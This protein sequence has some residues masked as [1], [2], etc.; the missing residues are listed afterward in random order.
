MTLSCRDI[1]VRDVNLLAVRTHTA[2]CS[3]SG[4]DGSVFASLRARTS[5]TP[6]PS[7]LRSGGGSFDSSTFGPPIGEPLSAT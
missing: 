1:F 3:G 6:M 4:P 5:T 7:A 2:T